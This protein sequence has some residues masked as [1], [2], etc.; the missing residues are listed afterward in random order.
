[1]LWYLH[2]KYAC[3]GGDSGQIHRNVSCKFKTVHDISFYDNVNWYII[4]VNVTDFYVIGITEKRYL[5]WF[6]S[7]WRDVSCASA[8]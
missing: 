6:L 4:I 8:A 2:V 5:K 3:I 1:M 7:H